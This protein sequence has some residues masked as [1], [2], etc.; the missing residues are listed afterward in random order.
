MAAESD[1]FRTATTWIFD[2]DNTLYPPS[3]RLF[4]QMHVRM[5]GF[6]MRELGLGRAEAERLRQQY[7]QSHGV[8]MA[9][10]V[11]HHGIDGAAFLA[12][13]HDLDLGVLRPDAG[14]RAAITAL[15]GLKIVHTNAARIHAERVLAA[16]G[17]GDAFARVFGIEDKRFVPKPRPQAYAHVVAETGI[18]AAH[19][20]MIEDDQRNLEVPKALGM[21][22]VWLCHHPGEKAAAHVDR[23][24]TRLERFLREIA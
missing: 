13:V 22:T 14:L 24:I 21:T 6:M 1:R 16:L 3:A 20:V 19:A 10:L 8:T 7:W 9:G 18:D 4:D 17:L 15:P 11:E 5:T 2:L 12:E 23:R